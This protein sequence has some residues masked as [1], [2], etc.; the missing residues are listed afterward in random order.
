MK[1]AVLNQPMNPSDM[2][3]IAIHYSQE[4]YGTNLPRLMG[5]NAAGEGFL[6]AYF[7][8]ATANDFF[9]YAYKRSDAEVFAQQMKAAGRTSPVHWVPY[10]Q[11]AGLSQAGLLFQPGPGLPE[12]CWQRRRVN[13][14]AYSICGL[15]HTTA[16]AGVMDAL[17]GLLTAPVHPWDGLICTSRAVMDSTRKLLALQV[18]YLK[19]RLGA[20]KFTGPTLAMIPLGV[21][22]NFF[23]PQPESCNLWRNKMG[24][25]SADIVFLFVGRLSFHAKAHPFPMY[26]ALEETARRTGKK[27]HLIQSGWFANQ[28]I[29][30]EFHSGAKSFC[31]S[32][33][34]HFLDGRMPEV[35]QNI[36][37]AADVFISLSD[38][39]Q[40]TF[41]LTPIEAMAAGLPCVVSDWD[42]YRD[43]VRHELDGF[44]IPTVMAPPPMGTDI[45]AAHEGGALSYDMYIGEACLSVAVDIP[46]CID[47]CCILAENESLRK[48]MGESA[49]ARAALVFDWKH[50]I[51]QYESFW[52][53]LVKI[54]KAGANKL[55]KPAPPGLAHPTRPDPFWL[56]S[57]YPTHLMNAGD[58]VNL[59]PEASIAQVHTFLATNMFNF[60]KNRLPS[61]AEFEKLWP[62][63]AENMSVGAILDLYPAKRRTY[64]ARGMLWLCKAG[65]LMIK[66]AKPANL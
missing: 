42:G 43:T 3:S 35:R 50:I 41:G 64:I 2:S 16:S 38:N 8:H 33:I 59:S 58:H 6:N 12:L 48:T 27:I 18:E 4:A 56:Y 5:R 7:E 29:E 13:E 47:A 10:G 45:A 44:K 21:D 25:S 23:N 19:E 34:A 57:G 39:I 20:Q 51:R 11:P 54:R 30:N 31:P 61:P 63:L 17:G 22:A 65:L 66:A 46:A 52:S 32:V 14:A 53:E 9:C 36:W 60:G 55:P 28:S 37:Q 26:A 15:T 24:I 40:E 49:R 1:G 62:R